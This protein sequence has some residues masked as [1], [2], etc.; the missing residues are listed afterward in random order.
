[1]LFVN[2]KLLRFALVI[3]GVATLSG[4]AWKFYDFVKHREEITQR[5]DL[6]ALQAGFG[7]TDSV[8]LGP[9]LLSYA[10][11]KVLQDLNI[12]GYVAPPPVLEGP[13]TTLPKAVFS[14]EDVDVPLIQSP[15]AAWIQG[16]AEQA[17]GDQLIGDFRVVGEIFELPSK[18]G[19]KL[20]LKSVQPGWVEIEVVE[21]GEV[22][23]VYSL[24]YEVDSSQVFLGDGEHGGPNPGGE[25][26]VFVSPSITRETEPYTYAVGKEDVAMLESMSQEQILSSLPHKIHRHPM[27]N[28]VD[29]ITIRSVPANSIF[30]RLGLRAEDIILDVNGQPA[31]DRDQLFAAMQKLDTDIL[32]VRIERLGGVRT[33]TFRLPK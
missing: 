29:G 13:T 12:T 1:M 3:A 19:L 20:R 32:K 22:F 24:T 23:Q 27:S 11:Y 28:E 16:R 31:T 17:N 25:G 10:E 5:L 21:S 2:E 30:E 4:F 14:A 8:P 26:A 33:L 9:H 18:A 15:T 7:N 6:K